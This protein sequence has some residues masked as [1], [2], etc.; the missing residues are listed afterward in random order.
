MGGRDRDQ[1]KRAWLMLVTRMWVRGMLMQTLAAGI[2]ATCLWKS[3][4]V[5][6]EQ[7]YKILVIVRCDLEK[8]P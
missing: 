6:R 3:R 7:R 4:A 8:E 1:N 2:F 5:Y